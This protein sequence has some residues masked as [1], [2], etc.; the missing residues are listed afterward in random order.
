MCVRSQTHFLHHF[1][2][3]I[4]T[5]CL[6][7]SMRFVG[8]QR[9]ERGEVVKISAGSSVGHTLRLCFHLTLPPALLKRDIR[10]CRNENIQAGEV[11]KVAM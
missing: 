7:S 11:K 8:S 6:F 5:P 9:E 10:G 3:T 4:F 1:F 2:T